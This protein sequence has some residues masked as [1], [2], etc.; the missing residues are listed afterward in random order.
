M[1]VNFC[2]IINLMFTNHRILTNH[3]ILKNGWI[4][5]KFFYE[6]LKDQLYKKV[7]QLIRL[8]ARNYLATILI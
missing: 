7:S 3:S 4:L 1:L 5:L 6:D 8:F 2:W